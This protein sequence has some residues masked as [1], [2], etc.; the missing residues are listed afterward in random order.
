MGA[1]W[2]DANNDGLLDLFVTVDGGNNFLY[3]NNGNGTFFKITNAS[4]VATIAHCHAPNWGDYD[5]DGFLDLFVAHHDNEGNALYQN[6]GDGTF[7]AI[8]NGPVFTDR[9]ASWGCASADYDNDGRLDLFVAADGGN[10]LYRNSGSGN[11]VKITNSPIV[12]AVFDDNWWARGGAWGD[13]DNDGNLD[14]FVTNSRRS[15]TADPGQ[16]NSLFHNNGDGSFTRITEGSIVNDGGVSIC[17]AWGDYDNDGFLDLFVSNFVIDPNNP[18]RGG[19]NNFLYRNNGNGTFSKITTGSLVNDGGSSAGCAWGDY[20]ND[21][22]LDLFVGNG[23]FVQNENNFLY[24]NNGNS[25]SWITFKLIGTASN[26]SAIGAKVRINATIGG[27]VLRQLR[28]ISGGS[29]F[30]SQNDL[31]P[32]FGLG[33]AT[34]IDL[35]RIEWSSGTVQE[36]RN[37]AVKQFLTVTEPP[38]LQGR[39]SDG[40]FQTTLTAWNGQRFAVERSS[41][42]MDWSPFAAVTHT[43]RTM[44]V[45][46]LPDA[47]QRFYRVRPE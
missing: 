19:Q 11:F 23:G 27:R 26:R 18:S 38:R 4:P 45:I 22:F 20:D 47:P 6:N 34:N 17:A 14:L 9:P 13:Y 1:A 3:R 29:G 15:G 8:T 40:Q 5:N 33:D 41:N 25:N 43:N 31:R 42:L 44:V 37:V 24:H 7:R 30:G 36:L 39:M 16:N 2:F 10:E 32:H 12:T 35:V 46:D 28:E 21:G